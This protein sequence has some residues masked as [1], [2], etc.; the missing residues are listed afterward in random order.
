MLFIGNFLEVVS[1]LIDLNVIICHINSD[2]SRLCHKCHENKH[3][4]AD[5]HYRNDEHK[6]LP[7]T[8][9]SLEDERSQLETNDISDVR[10]CCPNAGYSTTRASTSP[11]TD[12]TYKAR[13]IY[14]LNGS[15]RCKNQTENYQTILDSLLRVDTQKANSHE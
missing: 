4:Q 13:E 3:G 8:L 2:L 5:I 10:T 12:R 6:P 9:M 14:T 15:D 1:I 7:I 11:S